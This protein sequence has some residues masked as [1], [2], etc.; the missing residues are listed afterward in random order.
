M[1]Y[2]FVCIHSQMSDEIRI[3]VSLILL[4]IAGCAALYLTSRL[5]VFF[6]F[7]SFA[8]LHKSITARIHTPGNGLSG[9]F[10][11]RLRRARRF[12]RRPDNSASILS[13]T[14]TTRSDPCRRLERETRRDRSQTV[15]PNEIALK[16]RTNGSNALRSEQ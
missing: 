13:M 9:E 7:F 8:F 11:W 5:L 15:N 14:T 2:G 6:F 10:Q 1:R 3:R 12:P 16:P 4:L